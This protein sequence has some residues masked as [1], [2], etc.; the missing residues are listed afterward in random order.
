VVGVTLSEGFLDGPLREK[1]FEI[2][3]RKF[4]SIRLKLSDFSCG[5]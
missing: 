5:A 1:K 3:L 2:I 4:S